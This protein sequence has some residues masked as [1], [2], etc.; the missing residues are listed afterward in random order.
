VIYLRY[1]NDLMSDYSIHYCNSVTQNGA[2]CAI[3]QV[4]S[5]SLLVCY[6]MR[7]VCVFWGSLFVHVYQLPQN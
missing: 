4:Q 1:W 2:L 6:A 7:L 3:L 5:H